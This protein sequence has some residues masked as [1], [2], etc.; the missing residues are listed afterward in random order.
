MNTIQTIAKNTGA[1][2]ISNVITS[3]LGFFLLIYLARYL[4]EVGFGKYSFALSFTTLFVVF[5]NLG[6]NN[7]IIREL[8][9]NKNLKIAKPKPA[10]DFSLWKTFV[11]GSIPFG[12]NAKYIFKLRI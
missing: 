4:G 6:M 8:A 10:I 2:A 1:L 12:L 9:R 7:Y 5:A 11:I 3:I